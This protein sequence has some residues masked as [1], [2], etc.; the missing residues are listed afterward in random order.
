S[1]AAASSRIRGR[2]SSCIA[3]Q[4]C[5]Q[6]PC[7]QWAAPL[8]V[9]TLFKACR[10]RG[11]DLAD[12]IPETMRAV[13][14]SEPGGPEVLQ[15]ESR[16]VPRPGPGDVLV[17][18]SHAGVNRPDCMQR[19][20]KYAPPPGASDLPGLEIS[21]HVVALGDGVVQLPLGQSI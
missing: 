12:T 9:H 17:A 6:P 15:I 4:H 7:C 14:I 2:S 20:G 3:V 1:R 10:Y 5:A 16:P 13:A 21:G 19:Q 8:G 18:V 11:G